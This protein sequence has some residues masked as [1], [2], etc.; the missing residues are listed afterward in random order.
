MRVYIAGKIGDLP[1]EVYEANFKEAVKSWR[2]HGHDVVSPLEL[3][4]NHDRTWQSYMFENLKAL[5]GCEGIVLLESWV[6]SPGARI[7]KAWAERLGLKVM[8][9]NHDVA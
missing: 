6:E 7:K 4:H 2:R 3:P 9:F 1:K 8:Y 5:S